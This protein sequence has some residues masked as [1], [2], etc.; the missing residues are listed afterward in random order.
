MGIHPE[1]HEFSIVK[2]IVK[3][4]LMVAERYNTKK[5][6]EV[7][8]VIG[9]LTFLKPLRVRFF[10]NLLTEDTIIKGSKLFIEEKRGVVKCPSCG[11]EGDIMYEEDPVHHIRIPTLHCPRCGGVVEVIGGRECTI[12]SIKVVA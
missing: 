8:L 6:A 4:I 5:V 7:N 11:Y 9:K 10:Y 3:S 1:M 12:K 2:Q